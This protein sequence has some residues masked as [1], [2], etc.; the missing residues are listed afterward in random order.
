MIRIREVIEPRSDRLARFC[1][2]YLKL[3][4]ELGRR[5]WAPAALIDCARSRV[6]CI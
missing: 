2:P 1:R 6:S 4:Q 5:G 3:V